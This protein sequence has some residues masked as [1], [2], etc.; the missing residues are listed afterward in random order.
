MQRKTIAFTTGV[1]LDANDLMKKVDDLHKQVR[2]L[3]DLL[4]YR[5]CQVNVLPDGTSKIILRPI[6]FRRKVKTASNFR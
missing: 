5:S 2:G 1:V 3:L 6:P 4:G